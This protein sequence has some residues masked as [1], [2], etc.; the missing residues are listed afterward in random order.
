MNLARLQFASNV[1]YMFLSHASLEQTEREYT[2]TKKCFRT[3][4]I[5]D[6]APVIQPVLKLCGAKYFKNRR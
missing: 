2:T 6:L 5:K 3:D 4:Y 1:H